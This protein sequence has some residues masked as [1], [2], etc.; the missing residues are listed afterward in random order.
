MV[1]LGEN[2]I[3]WSSR[4]QKFVAPS[5]CEAEILSIR[6][7]VLKVAYFVNLAKELGL[8]QE[9]DKP[10][11]IFNDNLS[12][13]HDSNCHY[14]LRIHFI[15][16]MIKKRVVEVEHIEGSSM[17][18]DLLTKPLAKEVLVRLLELSNCNRRSN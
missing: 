10:V 11:T 13:K 9:N 12:A 18:A 15:M 14:R 6:D 17:R 5:T 8:C 4:K 16:D 1:F 3:Y 2:L 7:C